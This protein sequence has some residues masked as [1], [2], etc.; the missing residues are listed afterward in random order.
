MSKAIALSFTGDVAE[1]QDFT[2]LPGRGVQGRFNGQQMLLGNHRLVHETGL[3]NPALEA[4]L[5]THEQQGRSVT[6]LA[7]KTRVLGFFAV[8]DTIKK[9][10]MQAIADLKKLGV[11]SVMLTGDNSATAKVIAA[12][13]GIA[14]ARGD[15]LPEAKLQVIKEMQ[16]RY[17][18]T[19]M[20]GDGINDAP[21]LAQ[22][23]IGFAMGA[24]GTD[25]AMEAADIVI[26]NDNLLRVAETIRLSRRTHAI[27]WQNIT[28]AL[29]IKSVFLVM[30]VF[31]NATMWMAVFADMGA[32]LLV[33]G[34]GL[35]LLRG[36]K[37][38]GASDEPVA[39]KSARA[40]AH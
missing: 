15:L 27:L 13:A 40:H 35:R 36:S 33:V 29:G 10:S 19:G 26:M 24:A 20:T 18:A 2:A 17:G 14:D 16:K 9:T 34:N 8:A 5:A 4:A 28:L 12:Q 7:D 21:A 11:V 38:A 32:S 6:L 22:A 30:A 25:T 39:P 3:C 31:G 37:A 23:D 1:V